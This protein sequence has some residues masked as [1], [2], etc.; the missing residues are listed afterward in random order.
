MHGAFGNPS[1]VAREIGGHFEPASDRIVKSVVGPVCFAIWGAKADA[2]VA[3][4]CK[5]STR[6][7]RRYMSGEIAIP[8][9]LLHAINGKLLQQ[10]E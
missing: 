3:T 10:F 6:N 8:A 4:I 1:V 7:A 2:E 5:C 9:P